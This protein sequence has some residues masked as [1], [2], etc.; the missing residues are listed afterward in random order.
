MPFQE[1]A[2]L[3]YLGKL[4]GLTFQDLQSLQGGVL[5]TQ[6]SDVRNGCVEMRSR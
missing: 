6:L 1:I 3:Y 4:P 2:L 5:Y